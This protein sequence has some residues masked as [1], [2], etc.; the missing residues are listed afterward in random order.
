MTNDEKYLDAF[1]S[2]LDISVEDVEK[3][4]FKSFSQWDSVGHVNLM[5]KIEEEFD[6]SLEADDILDFTS[7]PAGKII[8]AKY[9]IDFGK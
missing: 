9:G 5:S 4:A 3:A 7:F 2:A 1:V 6:V 8:L